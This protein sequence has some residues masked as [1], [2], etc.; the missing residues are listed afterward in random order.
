MK[1]MTVGLLAM[2]A[3]AACGVGVGDPEGQ[4]A[5]G[6]QTGQALT[7]GPDGY[8]VYY[9]GETTGTPTLPGSGGINALPQDPVPVHGGPNMLMVLPTQ[10][11]ATQGK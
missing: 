8:P 4:A 2:L 6:V 3:M 10:S 9:P 5:L 11:V 7:V 1:S